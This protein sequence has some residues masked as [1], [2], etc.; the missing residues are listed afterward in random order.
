MLHGSWHI[1][2]Q[3][4]IQN[5]C[6]AILSAFLIV[7]VILLWYYWNSFLFMQVVLFGSVICSSVVM[8]SS[9]S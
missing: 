5:R 1:F 9:S 4:V 8:L 3:F 6:E 7:G 2:V